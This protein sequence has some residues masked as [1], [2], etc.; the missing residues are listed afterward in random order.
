MFIRDDRDWVIKCLSDISGYPTSPNLIIPRWSTA[1][2]PTHKKEGFM[3]FN[4][5]TKKFDYCTGSGWVSL[6]YAAE[7]AGTCTGNS[8][9]ATKATN[10]VDGNPI[11]TTYVKE[12]SVQIPTG[13]TTHRGKIA[14]FTNT[15]HIQFP[16]GAELWV[17]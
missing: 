7:T 16:N 15:G 17:V 5:D 9:T 13:E 2:R 4:T 6:E 3:G 1:N 11:K 10:D 14:K 8:A 12:S